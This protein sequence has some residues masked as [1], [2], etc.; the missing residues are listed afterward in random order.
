[1]KTRIAINGFGRIGRTAFKIAFRRSD[2]EIVA[3]NDL[4]D[5]KTLAHLLKHDS[6]YHNYGWYK[7]IEAEDRAITVDGVTIPIFSE[8]DPSSLPWKKLGVDVVIES[9]GFF[10]EYKK[11]KAHIKAGAGKV[12]ISAPAKGD[13]AKTYILGVNDNDLKIDD[14]VI[15][16]GSCTTN[17]V[18]PVIKILEDSVG[19]KKSMMTTVHSY[20]NTQEIQDAPNKSLREA[21]AAASNIIPT[22]TGSSQ[23]VGAAMPETLGLFNGISIRVPNPVVS[24]IDVTA[25]TKKRTTKEELNS[26]FEKASKEARWQG[27][28]AVSN[29]ELVSSDYIGNSH[30]AIV[31]LGLTDVVGGDLVKIVAWYDNEWGYS[32]R[33]IEICVDVNNLR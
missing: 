33:L 32:N 2:V 9:T 30:S 19:I 21:R 18:A 27:I 4:S 6:T 7:T 16:N 15:S 1:M 25:L 26:I 8:K 23:S 12:V 31:D 29:E 5:A 28:V 13:G 24:L 11:A 3:I 10:T 20:T 22:A 17:C 14:F